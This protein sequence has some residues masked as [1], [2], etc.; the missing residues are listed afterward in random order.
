MRAEV[1]RA[2]ETIEQLELNVNFRVLAYGEA[3]LNQSIYHSIDMV[4]TLIEKGQM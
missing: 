4:N 2:K 3:F 1:A